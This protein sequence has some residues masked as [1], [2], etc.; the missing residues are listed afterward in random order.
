MKVR[1]ARDRYLASNGF[2]VEG[3]TAPTFTL[4]VFG[5]KIPFRNVKS[6]QAVVPFHDLH[7]VAT[8]YGTDYAGEAE[9]GAWELRAGCNRFI[10]YYLNACAVL[11]GLV[12]APRRTLRAWRATAGQRTLY[13]LAAPYEETLEW[14]V[15]ELRGRL[16]IARD[17][18]AR[19]SARPTAPGPAPPA[20]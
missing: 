20:T 3:Y 18:A 2:T 9:I 15:E 8:G 12:I 7:H 4:D 13:V 14:T 11:I 1:E 16:G 6:R 5:W 19:S 10:L 17:P